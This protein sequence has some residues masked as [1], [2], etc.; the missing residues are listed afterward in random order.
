MNF[1]HTT[2]KTMLNPMITSKIFSTLGN[3]SSL[4][5]LGVKDMSNT[6]GI[7]AGSY[8]TGDQIEGKD[9]FIDELG[10][11][12]IWLL[13]IPFF[14]KIIDKTVYKL[15]KFN[16]NIDTR[17]LK[18]KD[19][20]KK[21]QE[22]APDAVKAS[23]DKIAKNANNEKV[24]K[25]LALAKFVAA[26]A[27]T[28][29][30]YSLLTS[31]RHKHT[32]KAIIKEIKKEE[33]AKKAKEAAVKINKD[34]KNPSFGMNLNSLSQFMFDPVKNTMIIDGGITTERLADARNPQDF[35]G[36]VIKEGGFWAFMYFAGPAIQKYMENKAAKNNKP[37]DLDIRVL[38]DEKFQNKMKT[39]TEKD[40]EKMAQELNLDKTDAQIYESLFTKADKED[41]FIVKIAK[42]SDIIKTIKDSNEIDTQHYI[43]IDAIKGLKGKIEN[44]QKSL[45]AESKEGLE[46]F[47]N[48]ILKL[49]RASIIT[50]IGASIGAL[51][52]LVP[53]IMV[54]MRF[55]DKDNKEFMVKKEI[56]EKM[57]KESLKD[58][59]LA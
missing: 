58:T 13:G 23:F 31:F 16:P 1:F 3:N 48:K 8:I 7:T 37:I 40:I 38:Q 42:Q 43:D 14:K 41:N 12:V 30:S 9:R 18:N 56:Y 24:F 2:Y 28:L 20:F 6:L 27:L 51:G 47:F 29:G 34:Q 59:N 46:T 36:Y 45:K 33:E 57:Q 53:A 49:K 44:L 52:L 10:T 35:M 11:Q 26:T 21:A 39:M 54:A 50:N 17:I 55:M 19:I 32:E 15:A 4:I 5:P 25:G 22:H